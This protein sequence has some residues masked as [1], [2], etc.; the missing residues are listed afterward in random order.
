MVAPAA[1]LS[2]L[3]G[4]G[5]HR[6]AVFRSR[7][8]FSGDRAALTVIHRPYPAKPSAPIIP[9]VPSILVLKY[10]PISSPTSGARPSQAAKISEVLMDW[11]QVGLSP[12]S[13]ID[14]RKL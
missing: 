10:S 13:A 5:S 14:V 1:T 4:T 6:L 7:S 8:A 2:M 12:P 11:R 9:A 3:N